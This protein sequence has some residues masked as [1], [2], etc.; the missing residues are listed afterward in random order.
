MRVFMRSKI[1]GIK[2]TDKNLKY[3]GSQT[4]PTSLLNRADIRGYEQVHVLN[5]TNGNRWVTYAIPGN[6]GECVLNGAA[7]RLGEIGDELIILAYDYGDPP[8]HPLGFPIPKIIHCD[9][10]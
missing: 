5:I 2:V 7:A 8:L 3:D 6:E 4:L 9:Q 10:G 1:H